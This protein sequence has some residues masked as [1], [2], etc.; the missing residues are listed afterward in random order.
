M[1]KLNKKIKQALD[2]GR[3]LILGTQALLGFEYRSFFDSGFDKLSLS[4]QYLKMGSLGIILFTLGL[5][6][7][8]TP[9]HQIV[10][11]GNDNQDSHRFIMRVTGLALFPFAFGLGIDFFVATQKLFGFATSIISGIITVLIAL[12]F[13]Y[14]IEAISKARHKEN[15]A[16][17]KEEENKAGTKME[18]KV[19][20]VLAE[21]RMVLPGAQALLG[22]RNVDVDRVDGIRRR[23]CRGDGDGRD[24]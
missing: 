8:A 9:Y 14:G 23:L 2:E 5:F 21:A 1:T 7:S 11:G 19:E 3:I 24:Q 13:W 4:S 10:E 16:M 20:Q 12:F 6:L 17:E 18:D 22:C 15:Q